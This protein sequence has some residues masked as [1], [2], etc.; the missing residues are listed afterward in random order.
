MLTRM[1]FPSANADGDDTHNLDDED[2]VT[3][4]APLRSGESSTVDVSLTGAGYLHA[5]IDFNHDGDWADAGEKIIAGV[6]NTAGTHTFPILVPPEAAIATTMAR[7][8]FASRPNLSYNGIAVDGEVEDYAVAILRGYPVAVPD[9][10]S[11]DEG[12]SILID[13]LANDYDPHGTVAIQTVGSAAHGFAVIESGKIRYTPNANYSGPDSFPYTIVNDIGLSESARVTLFVFNVNSAP[14]DIQIYNLQALVATC[15]ASGVCTLPANKLVGTLKA[16]DPDPVDAHIFNLVNSSEF[17]LSGSALYT[18]AAITF[19]GSDQSIQRV[20]NVSATDSGNL[21]FTKAITLYILGDKIGGGP[22]LITLSNYQVAEN[23]PAAT[24]VGTLATQ[25]DTPHAPYT[26]TLVSGEGSNDN[27]KF[28]INGVR[29][30]TAGPLDF[31]LKELNKVRIRTLSSVGQSKDQIFT[32][33][34]LDVPGEPAQPPP[35]CSV[36]QVELIDSGDVQLSVL[37]VTATNVTLQGCD[38][39]GDLSLSFPGWSG[40]GFAFVGKVNQRN[41]VTAEAGGI[42]TIDMQVAG[43]PLKVRE[44]A[45]EFYDGRSGLRLQNASFCLPGDWGGLCAPALGGG[46]SMLIDDSG[47]KMGAGLKL[48][49]PDIKVG[50]QVNLSG[51]TGMFIPVPGGYEITLGGKLG[52]PKFKPGKASDCGISASV[53]LY[54]G[55]EGE[56]VMEIQAR[57]SSINAVGLRE[58]TVGV[59]CDTGIPIDSTGLALT[60]VEGTVSLRPDSKYVSLTLTVSTV[61]KIPGLNISPIKAEGTAKLMW[62]PEWGL[63]LSSTVYLLEVFKTSQTAVSIRPNRLSFTANFTSFLVKGELSINAWTDWSSFHLTGRG[64][65]EVGFFK[66]S[67]LHECFCIPYPTKVCWKWCFPYPCGWKKTCGCLDI[68]PF[69]LYVTLGAEFGEFTN[70]A[71]GFKGYVDLPILGDVGIYI[72]SEP[73]LHIGGMSKYQLVT[74]P[75]ILEALRQWRT[76]RDLGIQNVGPVPA[77]QSPDIRVI[78]DN[79]VTLRVP[80]NVKSTGMDAQDQ[81]ITPVE[82]ETQKNTLFTLTSSKPLLMTLQAPDGTLITPSN[83]NQPPVTPNYT[84]EYSQTFNYQSNAPEE[85]ATADQPRL[86]FVLAATH[87]AW[88]EVNVSL[89]GTLLFAGLNLSDPA[90]VDYIPIIP[91]LHTLAI[92]PSGGGTPLTLDFNADF[93]AYYTVLASGNGATPVLTALTDDH[94][95]PSAQGMARLR[96]VHSAPYS[97]PVDVFVKGVQVLDD[98]SALGQSLYFEFA[99]GEALVEIKDATSGVDIA[100]A[101]LIDLTAG[102]VYSL[103]DAVYPVGGYQLAWGQYLDEAFVDRYYTQYKVYQAPSGMWEVTMDGDLDT[104]LPMLSVLGFAN[105]PQ[106][107]RVEAQASDPSHP[108]LTWE[109]RSDYL[110]TTVSIYA[111]PSVYETGGEPVYQGLQIA[112]VELTNPSEVGGI[113]FLQ[114]V[115]LSTLESGSYTLWVRVQDGVNPPISA[116]AVQP[117]SS[118]VAVFTINQ[119]TTFP[120]AWN[121]AI[122]AVLSSAQAR[123]FLEWGA[124]AHPDVDSYN[125]YLNT[126]PLAPVKFTEGL[127]AFR[128]TNAAGEPFGPVLV[129]ASVSDLVPGKTYYYSVEAVDT[130]GG[131]SV[132][133]PEASIAIP[134]GDFKLTAPSGQYLVTPG[135]QVSFPLSLEVT[136]PLFYTNV[137]LSIDDSLT[138][139]GMRIWFDTP[140]EGDAYLNATD[141]D[142]TVKVD[143]SSAVPDGIYP[144]TFIGSNGGMERSRTVYILVNPA[145]TDMQISGDYILAGQDQ[146]TFTFTAANLGTARG[147]GAQVNIPFPP[148]IT[149]LTWTCLGTGGV[150]CGSGTGS[151]LDWIGNFLPG[152]TATYTIAGRYR[153]LSPFLV[154]ADLSWLGVDPNLANNHATVG[155]FVNF[156]SRI[157][158]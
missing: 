157:N 133:S 14:T 122:S 127:S 83:Y 7:F 53:V 8:R 37:N 80:V 4:T 108:Q 112:Q 23:L 78:S 75:G 105:P 61:K 141:N 21:K 154:T 38:I 51:L 24:L 96:F 31:E 106:W 85:A 117:G 40:G 9:S 148:G 107:E 144:V 73:S 110:P 135:N 58:I 59:S 98:A 91:G 22:E 104:S 47:L 137:G 20:V 74:P 89:D 32:I 143:L 97:N 67:I 49:F 84:V 46:V 56:V 87:P 103:F 48:E 128:E 69:S 115:D 36:T 26:Y 123:L 65:V 3:F 19:T 72:D 118:T 71:W 45:L 10:V 68:L 131:K 52:L 28:Q 54:A 99:A 116:Y 5:W 124:L 142:V 139:P 66:G 150:T 44:A 147:D 60:G 79:Q 43:V 13:V 39:A 101:Q 102:G 149:N 93:K 29:L 113:P 30:E 155:R 57:P 111:N 50:N 11:L 153:R 70:G 82:L 41:Q 42:A 33:Q 140:L 151:V 6:Y 18:Q 27:A 100:P 15:N 125:L 132:R 126:Q 25:E 152:G 12:T 64:E 120:A 34:L 145:P 55:A 109:L 114:A 90:P 95:A 76:A 35:N 121:P 62:D 88:A 92:V 63:D 77:A 119:S 158:R 17:R 1:E 130:E 16:V 81:E 156:L 136:L 94:T 86:R 129:N 138:P 146:V 2:G 134:S